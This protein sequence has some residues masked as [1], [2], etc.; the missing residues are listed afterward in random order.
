MILSVAKL[1]PASKCLIA[2]FCIEPE[3]RPVDLP[4]VSAGIMTVSYQALMRHY[5][6]LKTTRAQQSVRIVAQSSE[7]LAIDHGLHSGGHRNARRTC[8]AQVR[9]WRND[10][11]ALRRSWPDLKRRR[12]LADVDSGNRQDNCWVDPFG[13]PYLDHFQSAGCRRNSGFCRGI[14]KLLFT[15]RPRGFV[16]L[17]SRNIVQKR[18]SCRQWVSPRPRVS[19]SSLVR[20]GG[21]ESQNIRSSVRL[22]VNCSSSPTAFCDLAFLLTQ[23]TRDAEYRSIPR[24]T[25]PDER[26]KAFRNEAPLPA[27]GGEVLSDSKPPHPKPQRVKRRA[28][29]YKAAAS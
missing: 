19:V 27:P 16:R 12:G 17:A 1:A 7:A 4:T 8:I 2:R 13:N 15:S 23:H 10:S 14:C 11:P 29:S 26:S 6:H 25:I 22:C 3:P 24:G 21:P 5:E 20:T 28:L 18:S 9:T